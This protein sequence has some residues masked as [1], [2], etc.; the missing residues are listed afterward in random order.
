MTAA[1]TAAIGEHGWTAAR[2]YI[3]IEMPTEAGTTTTPTGFTTCSNPRLLRR[4][5][6]HVHLD[7]DDELVLGGMKRRQSI[8][9]TPR[10]S[11]TDAALSPPPVERTSGR[12]C[13]ARMFRARVGGVSG[14]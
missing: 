1:S 4:Q 13:S 3:A 14:S 6:Q 10:P 5:A 12:Q 8:C 2:K 7:H 11:I 9:A